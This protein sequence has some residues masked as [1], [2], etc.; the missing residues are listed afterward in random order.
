M[1][2]ESWFFW[3]QRH[4]TS[5]WVL[6]FKAPS[7]RWAYKN[8][9]SAFTCGELGVAI[10]K[11]VND[12][13]FSERNGWRIYLGISDEEFFK[14]EVDARAA[15]L[16]HLLERKIITVEEVNARLMTA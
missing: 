16:V 6:D 13:S 8:I 9:T 10:G 7:V 15:M 2:Q 4:V 11:H 12:V 14:K 5:T 3:Y 1:V